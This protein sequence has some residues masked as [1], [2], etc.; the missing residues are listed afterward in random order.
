MNNSLSTWLQNY[1]NNSSLHAQS[2]CIYRLSRALNMPFSLYT[3]LRLTNHAHS[4]YFTSY[5][6]NFTKADLKTDLM[7]K[8]AQKATH[9][10]RLPFVARNNKIFST[11]IPTTKEIGFSSLICKSKAMTPAPKERDFFHFNSLFKNNADPNFNNKADSGFNPKGPKYT[12]EFTLAMCVAL[13]FFATPIEIQAVPLDNYAF[14]YLSYDEV[15]QQQSINT[16]SQKSDKAHQNQKGKNKSDSAPQNFLRDYV[17]N[18]PHSQQRYWHHPLETTE[19]QD[20]AFYLALNNKPTQT[21]SLTVSASAADHVQMFTRKAESTSSATKISYALPAE[22]AKATAS[23]KTNK[24]FPASKP[25]NSAKSDLSAKSASSSYFQKSESEHDSSYDLTL[26][27][28]LE[29]GYDPDAPLLAYNEALPTEINANSVS[30]LNKP[31]LTRSLPQ[32]PRA[33]SISATKN[34]NKNKNTVTTIAPTTQT[35]LRTVTDGTKTKANAEPQANSVQINKS[36]TRSTPMTLQRINLLAAPKLESKELIAGAKKSIATLLGHEINSQ[37]LNNVLRQITR[38]YQEEQGFSQAQAY[39][40][41]QS[42]QSGSLDLVVASPI[43]HKVQVTNNNSSTRANYLDYLLTDL[44]ELEGQPIQHAELNNQMLRLSDLGVFSLSG[45]FTATDPSGLNQ[46]LCLEAHEFQHRVSLYAFADN[47]GTESSGRYRI[48]TQVRINNILGL[49]DQLSLF[50]AR[51]DKY[52]NNY[53]I[54]YKVPLNSHATTLGFEFGYNDYELGGWYRELGA[55]G[56]SYFVESY[57]NEPTYRDAFNSVNFKTGIRYRKLEDEFSNFDLSFKKHSL[58]AYMEFNGY[59]LFGEKKNHS[60]SFMQRFST[61]H[62]YIDDDWKIWEEHSYNISNTNLN[63]Q[64]SLNDH[65]VTTTDLTMQLADHS[66]EGS[67]Q[68]S[69]AGPY[70]LKAFA[71]SDLS[72]DS[73]VV[74][75]QSI[76]CRPWLDRGLTITPH[77]EFGHIDNKE[78]SRDSAIS[79]GLTAQYITSSGFNFNVDFSKSISAKPDYAKDDSRINF[80]FSYLF[81]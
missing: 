76:T 49:A 43:L 78:Q 1:K 70:G 22:A 14:E 30:E 61:G 68:F 28:A 8:P 20:R 47:Y 4:N 26:D 67:E 40:P 15:Q 60:F 31:R 69:A 66:L 50:Y 56:N 23:S 71:S 75:S 64:I 32:A 65:W 53:N 62:L 9:C 46:D 59:K 39:L 45:Q 35:S 12:K 38:Y 29:Y 24:S 5:A 33:S 10:S 25:T 19:P 57:I 44:K 77:V 55:K 7:P 2:C 54:S 11:K 37:L 13:S 42:I 52:Q 72:G 73:G 51:T 21:A 80:T 58:L 79:A 18:K 41:A 36:V 6:D 3:L 81:L 17:Q 48:G 63:M 16:I 27:D 74:L 34:K